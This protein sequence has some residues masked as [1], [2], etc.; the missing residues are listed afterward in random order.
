MRI[1]I[2]SAI[3]EEIHSFPDLVKTNQGIPEN[4]VFQIEHPKHQ[5]VLSAG[6][7]G[8]VNSAIASTLLIRELHIDFLINSGI[9][10]ALDP[11]LKLEEV[12][13]GRRL[14]QHDYGTLIEGQMKVYP[15]GSIPLGDAYDP[16]FMPPY[17]LE[18][19]LQKEMPKFR[20]VTVLSGD[21]FL[22]CKM[23]REKLR[24]LFQ[25]QLVD[26]ESAALAQV[27]F[28]FGIPFLSVRA[29]SDHVGE[30]PEGIPR[31]QLKRASRASAETVMEVIERLPS[32]ITTES[33]VG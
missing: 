23:K 12:C 2:L 4:P 8:K 19:K 13:F 25:A 20:P 32:E 6:G 28:R 9:A 7:L 26:M 10:G 27:A 16:A 30:H 24:E 31:G 5:L 22:Q 17:W 29:V 33:E 18:Q 1:G 14:I 15:S 21:V 11:E 3:P